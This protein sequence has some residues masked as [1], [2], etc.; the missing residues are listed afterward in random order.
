MANGNIR[1]VLPELRFPD[2][3]R[4]YANQRV[5]LT[6]I[7]Q[8]TLLG[9]L[10][11]T[12]LPIL[13]SVSMDAPVLGLA[14]LLG[15]VWLIGRGIASRTRLSEAL[16][17]FSEFDLKD[18]TATIRAAIELANLQKTDQKSYG[19]FKRAVMKDV[20]LIMRFDK[21]N[22]ERIESVSEGDSLAE[23]FFDKGGQGSRIV[24]VPTLAARLYA[25][26]KPESP[27]EP[28]K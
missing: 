21:V 19:I 27:E 25:M 20:E 22:K 1:N 15:P 6:G 11:V 4:G 8:N 2:A 18:R 10:F 23:A 9:S 5:Q 14:A 12:A 16:R 24:E 3:L 13:A 17:S 26:D 7:R 28:K